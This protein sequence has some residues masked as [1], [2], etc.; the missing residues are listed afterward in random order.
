MTEA[1]ARYIVNLGGTL[2]WV[3]IRFC[4]TDLQEEKTKQKSVRNFLFLML[5][6]CLIAFVSIKAT[7]PNPL[8]VVNGI[9]VSKSEFE[10][11][12]RNDIESV[13]EFKGDAATAIYGEKGRNGV[14]LMTLS[15]KRK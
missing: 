6:C 7:T 9:I 5:I 10:K 8:Y 14:L 12:E 13:N 15:H 2:W 1:R 3:L 4:R 11:Y